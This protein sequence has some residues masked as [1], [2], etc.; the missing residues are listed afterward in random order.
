MMP[1]P[2]QNRTL[3]SVLQY[4][5]N[6]GVGGRC[7]D[8]GNFNNRALTDLLLFKTTPTPQISST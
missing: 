8:E 1:T 3:S 6:D 5:N 4:R 7:V 2:F